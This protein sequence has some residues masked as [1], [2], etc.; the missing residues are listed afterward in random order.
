MIFWIV[1]FFFFF[2]FLFNTRM[3]LFGLENVT[4]AP[5]E[6]G[7]SEGN[8]NL[9]WTISV[10]LFVFKKQPTISVVYLCT[11]RRI[12]TCL[13]GRRHDSGNIRPLN[14]LQTQNR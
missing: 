4:P 6:I 8:F 12:G 1:D 13:S 7:V 11:A 10:R 2:F 5:R 9:E 14:F 3:H